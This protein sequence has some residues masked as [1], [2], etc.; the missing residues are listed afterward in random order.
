MAKKDT[1]TTK[2]IVTTI[3]EI[4][5]PTTI[6]IP[7][8]HDTTTKQIVTTTSEIE[9]PTTI[10]IPT[11]SPHDQEIALTPDQINQL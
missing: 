3:S 11:E 2:Q 4:E 7:T 6:P 8:E 1:T 5:V 10:P 9:V